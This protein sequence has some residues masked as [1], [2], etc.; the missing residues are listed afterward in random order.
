MLGAVGDSVGRVVAVAHA[1]GTRSRPLVEV[2][3]WWMSRCQ[4]A[5]WIEQ[6][7]A[8]EL[9]VLAAEEGVNPPELLVSLLNPQTRN[10]QCCSR[11]AADQVDGDVDRSAPRMFL[12]LVVVEAQRTRLSPSKSCLSALR[13]RLG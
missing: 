10:E 8:A 6:S 1:E 7:A 12:I 3:G 5:I 11:K 9:A 13:L 4:S 2:S